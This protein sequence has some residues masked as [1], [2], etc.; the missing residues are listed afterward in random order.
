MIAILQN[1]SCPLSRQILLRIKDPLNKTHEVLYGIISDFPF[2]WHSWKF[3]LPYSYCSSDMA[4]QFNTFYIKILIKRI[5]QNIINPF[6]HNFWRAQVWL[7]LWWTKM[8]QDASQKEKE[9]KQ[10]GNRKIFLVLDSIFMP[11]RMPIVIIR[12]YHW[13]ECL[14]HFI[15]EINDTT[16][17]V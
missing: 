16:S 14:L 13:P 4:C 12:W 2:Y 15:Q 10:K 6:V 3:T 7:I 8:E 1:L 9:N 11:W 17:F 5:W